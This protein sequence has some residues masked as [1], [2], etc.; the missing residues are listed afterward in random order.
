MRNSAEHG[1]AKYRAQAILGP[2]CGQKTRLI[3][4][5]C[6]AHRAYVADG[7]AFGTLHKAKSLWY[8]LAMTMLPEHWLVFISVLPEKIGELLSVAGAWKASEKE[9]AQ[10]KRLV[11]ESHRSVTERVRSHPAW[12]GLIDRT[13]NLSLCPRTEDETYLVSLI[14]DH[15]N[16][17][18][19]E[20]RAGRYDLPEYLPTDLREFFSC[21][22]CTDAWLELRTCYHK[23][24]VAYV[25]RTVTSLKPA[26]SEP[27]RPPKAVWGSPRFAP[28]RRIRQIWARRAQRSR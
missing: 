11:V 13:R 7:S 24:T 18:M 10:V 19:L 8:A 5:G 2:L 14:L 4:N 16:W 9:K 1:T 27:S 6:A 21:P 20:H 26:E 23:K 3:P 12:S 15:F 28:L 22:V 25:E 17:V